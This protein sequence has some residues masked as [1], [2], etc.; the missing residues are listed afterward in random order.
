MEDLFLK[1]WGIFDFLGKF[2]PSVD[3][4]VK[5]RLQSN[6]IQSQH[7]GAG[8]RSHLFIKGTDGFIGLFL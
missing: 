6:R 5:V 8:L 3:Y 1:G 2:Y 4:N 7:C